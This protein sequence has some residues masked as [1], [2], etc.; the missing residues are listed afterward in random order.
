[1]P[2]PRSAMM[3]IADGLCLALCCSSILPLTMSSEEERKRFERHNG[4]CGRP[5]TAPWWTIRHTMTIYLVVEALL[6]VSGLP[7][8]NA[9]VV[10]FKDWMGPGGDLFDV[11]DQHGAPCTYAYAARA[12][13][14]HLPTRYS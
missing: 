12:N 14:H 1:M 9:A 13:L 11:S 7:E 5:D 8:V 2:P 6:V 4:C 10:V 3:S